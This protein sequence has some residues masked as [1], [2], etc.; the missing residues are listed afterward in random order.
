MRRIL[1]L[2]RGQDVSGS[3]RQL[4][5]LVAGLD[6]RHYEPI[7]VCSEPGIFV[8]KLRN[9]GI[10]TE[11]LSMRS[12]RKV[13]N[14]FSRYHDLRR[15]ADFA[16]EHHISLVHCSYLW[17]HSYAQKLSRILNRPTILHLRTPL[18][19]ADISK[20]KCHCADSIISISK[21]IS[22]QLISAGI[23]QSRIT[24]ISD[25]V[26]LSLFST[27]HDNTLKRQFNIDGSVVFGIVGRVSKQK[28]QHVFLQ[29]AKKVI[30]DG[31]NA[32]FFIIGG[33]GSQDYHTELIES[34][35]DFKLQDR[36][37]LTGRREDMAG[38]LSSLDILVSLSGGSVM[39]EAMACGRT[40]ISAGFT[41]KQDSM[42]LIDGQ[43][44]ILLEHLDVE[45]LAEV[46]HQTAIDKDLRKQLGDNARKWALDNFS[47]Q[48][49]IEK[50]TG[51]YRSL[52]G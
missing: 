46:M 44:G 7:V 50:T 40:V 32:S 43:T 36:V 31:L 33:I 34:I 20:H 30:E 21:R 26:D 37:F 23:D 42:H 49:L 17:H 9:A 12:W 19:A 39:Y 1:I 27:T 14:L 25:A 45:S 11:V 47:Q 35:K 8:D 15:L 4:L 10:K 6:K 18:S 29:A 16:R 24:T 3:Q 13:R 51:V 41:S 48:I 28:R 38:I 52:I 2:S 5:Y 22:R